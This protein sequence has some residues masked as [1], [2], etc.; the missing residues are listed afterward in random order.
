MCRKS[1]MSVYYGVT[2]ILS[3]PKQLMLQ[4]MTIVDPLPTCIGRRL[5]CYDIEVKFTSTSIVWRSP[6]YFTR[7]RKIPWCRKSLQNPWIESLL[8]KSQLQTIKIWNTNLAG[9]SQNFTVIWG[10]I[11]SICHESW[12]LTHSFMVSWSLTRGLSWAVFL[13]WNRKCIYYL[14]FPALSWILHLK[15]VLDW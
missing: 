15:I 13:N 12:C 7:C 14:H 11:K 2:L 4:V 8:Q 10:T 9:N 6:N 5:S 3:P 1:L